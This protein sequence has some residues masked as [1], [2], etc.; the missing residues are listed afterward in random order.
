MPFVLSRRNLLG[1]A[2]AAAWSSAG[3][4]GRMGAGR[5]EPGGGQAWP[6]GFLW[7]AGTSAHQVEGG[8]SNSDIWLIESLPESQFADRSGSACDHYRRYERDIAMVAALGYNTFRFSIEWARVEPRPGEFS[9]EA[10]RHYRAVLEACRRRGLRTVVTLFHFTAPLWLATRGGFL[11]PEVPGLF[12][13]YAARVA[14]HCGDLINWV[15]TINEANMSFRDYVPAATVERLLGAAARASG[16]DRFGTFLFDDV[17]RSKPIVRQAHLAARAAIRQ[18]RPH[19]PVGL[20]LAIQDVQD[21]PGANGEGVRMR[22]HLY[23]DWLA[24]ARDDDYVG[25]QNYTRLLYGP[26]GLVGPPPGTPA[27]QLQQ[28]I[29]PPSLG[30]AVRYAASVSR[31][32]VLV[33]EHGI[34]TPDDRQRIAFIADALKGL[35]SAMADGVD[36]RGYLHWSLLDNYEWAMG[37][38]PRFGLVA[39]DR[40]TQQRRPKP[41][42][43]FLARQFRSAGAVPR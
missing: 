9:V 32:P 4:S 24:L 12:A 10:L 33:T 40:R 42:A 21:A 31:V 11:N 25:V 18:V 27:S 22:S 23:D 36:V 43:A 6:A 5:A 26:D 39:V 17:A 2:A 15:S 16:S 3:V 30:N 19:L 34:G 29:Y 41:S 35:R 37:Y 7:G 28:E 38:G 13:R 20:T 14:D 1:A 8:N